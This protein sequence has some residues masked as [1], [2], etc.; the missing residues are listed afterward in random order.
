[1]KLQAEHTWAHTA[2]RILHTF[3]GTPYPDPSQQANK[4]VA[5]ERAP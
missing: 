3:A 2:Q 4:P 1:L 5:P